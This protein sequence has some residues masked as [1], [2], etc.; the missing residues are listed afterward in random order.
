MGKRQDSDMRF[1]SLQY[2][3]SQFYYLWKQAGGLDLPIPLL[4]GRTKKRGQ[5]FACESLGFT[6][7]SSS[8]V[9]A[10]W[11]LGDICPQRPGLRGSTKLH[12]TENTKLELVSSDFWLARGRSWARDLGVRILGTSLPSLSSE[13]LSVLLTDTT[14]LL[15]SRTIGL[16]TLKEKLL[17]ANLAA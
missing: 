15:Q 5:G 9:A 4:G 2:L 6:P 17:D 11:W 3:C 8:D 1:F 13:H 12:P 14:H 16:P 7:A 10:Q